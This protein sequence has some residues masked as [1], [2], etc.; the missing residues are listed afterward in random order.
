MLIDTHTHLNLDAFDADRDEVISR[1]RY[2]GVVGLIVIGFDLETIRTALD[3][4]RRRPDI[5]PTAGFHPHDASKVTEAGK[6]K[7]EKLAALPEVVAIGEAGLDYYRDY[8]PRET[9]EEV[10]RWQIGLSNRLGKPLIIHSRDSHDD[11]VRILREEGGVRSGGVFHAFSGDESLAATVL[12][13]GFHVGI[14]GP[15]TYRKSRLGETTREIPLERILVETD[16]PWLTPHPHRGKRNEPG[17][18]RL[19]AEKL[20]EIRS[21]SVEEIGRVTT[22]NAERLFRLRRKPTENADS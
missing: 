17:Y 13:L 14:G 22:E 21:V 3:L 5:W 11:V 7:L 15:L 2:A 10:F 9:Q 4:S 20:A 8:S 12:E 1:A 16:C 6:K 19:V 18:V